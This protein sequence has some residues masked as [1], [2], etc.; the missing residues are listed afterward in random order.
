MKKNVVVIRKTIRMT[1]I[2]SPAASSSSSS[3]LL[4]GGITSN[5]NVIVVVDDVDVAPATTD[6]GNTA[7]T[8]NK[9]PR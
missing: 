1:M 5:A 4:S 3:L 8:M 2:L 9:T 6:T 7:A